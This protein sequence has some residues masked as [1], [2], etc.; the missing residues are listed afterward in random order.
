MGFLVLVPSNPEISYFQLAEGALNIMKNHN[1]WANYPVAKTK[2]FAALVCYLSTQVQD[3]FP[4]HIAGVESNDTI[5][6]GNDEFR[7]E[8]E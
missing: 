6:I 3:S 1:E 5:F 7:Q 4:C 2:V 8:A